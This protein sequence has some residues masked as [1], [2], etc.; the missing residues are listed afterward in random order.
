MNNSPKIKNR[1]K[2]KIS[3]L[4]KKRFTKNKIIVNYFGTTY[5]K[6]ALLSYILRPFKKDSLKHTNYF[7]AQSWA[8]V[9]SCLGYNV[10]VIDFRNTQKIDLSKYDVICGF[11]NAFQDY[12]ENNVRDSK[13]IFYATG[14]HMHHQ[15][16]ASLQRV[17]DV[18]HKKGVWLAKSARF[19]EKT[20]LHQTMLVDGIIAL[21][22]EVCA[23]SYQK[24]Y[25]GKVL[26][27]PSPFYKTQDAEA[28]FKQRGKSANQHFLW[29]GSAGLIHKGL[30]LVLDYFLKNQNLTLHVCGKIKNDEAFAQAY[31][32]ELF[33]TENIITHGF[34]DIDSN[35]FKN[36]L[37]SCSFIIYPSCS[38]G[39]S[40]S[41]LT[42]IGNG[43]LI[44]IISKET[45]FSAGFEIWIDSLDDK[46]I[47]KAVKQALSLSNEDI[48]T[49][50][51]KNYEYVVLNNS[52]NNYYDKLK[53]AI[54]NILESKFA[55]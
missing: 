47:D 10:D 21:G 3:R 27:I 17:K 28:I 36:V 55:P 13:T 25:D 30:D 11:G 32:K 45:T 4:I 19:V 12:F 8:K 35:D 41:A 16:T 20:W 1:I 7:E 2:E 38:E 15:N 22:N 46:G 23:Q 9:L 26:S 44:P 54:T 50:Q 14:M 18:Y 53:S 34:I 33:A 52:Q 40:P 48:T 39:G 49:L 6:T 5:T 43:G 51:K 24:Y 37:K 42:A 29:F 31:Q